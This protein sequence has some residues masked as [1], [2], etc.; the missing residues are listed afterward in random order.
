M[1]VLYLGFYSR[2]IEVGQNSQNKQ[3]INAKIRSCRL[4]RAQSSLLVTGTR[5]QGNI[6]KQ[7]TADRYTM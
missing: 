1:N 7:Y 6:F 5:Y 4:P 3:E 2:T